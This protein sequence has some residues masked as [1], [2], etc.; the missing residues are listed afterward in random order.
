MIVDIYTNI[1]RS[2]HASEFYV[3]ASAFPCEMGA[4][5][6]PSQMSAH[7]ESMEEA[8]K[9]RVELARSL[10]QTLTGLGHEVRSMVM[11]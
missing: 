10:R 9:V 8:E 7:A 11:R 4:S 6:K 2:V 3:V 1:F 5:L